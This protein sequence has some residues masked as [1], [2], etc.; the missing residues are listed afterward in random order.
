[1]I[2]SLSL[3]GCRTVSDVSGVQ[4]QAIVWRGLYNY[5]VA[6]MPKVAGTVALAYLYAGYASN[7]SQGATTR[8]RTAYWVAAGVTVAIVPFTF[9][10]MQPTNDELMAA[11]GS[12]VKAA[13]FG[14]EHVMQLVNKWAAL[15]L[16]RS[17]LPLAGAVLGLSAFVESLSS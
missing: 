11:A 7:P 6:L 3:I 9:V 1:M 5:G 16:V 4:E 17:L 12:A 15:N 8:A 13:A 14:G 2:A 10:F